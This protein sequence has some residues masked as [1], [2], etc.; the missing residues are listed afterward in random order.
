M[1]LRKTPNG[2]K[3]SLLKAP[4]QIGHIELDFTNEIWRPVEGLPFDV[5]DQG[6]VKR[7]NTGRLMMGRPS[8][9]TGYI[10]LCLKHAEQKFAKTIP[11]HQLV[12]KAFLPNP[13]NKPTVDHINRIRH[14]NRLCNLRWATY[15]EQ[16]KNR[17][18]TGK[19]NANR[20]VLQIDITTGSTIAEFE[21]ISAAANSIHDFSNCPKR[22]AFAYIQKV[23]SGTKDQAFGY[24]WKLVDIPDFDGEEWKTLFIDGFLFTI[25][26]YGRIQAKNGRRT[27]G[28]TDVH[29]YKSCMSW[30]GGTKGKGK[31]AKIHR[32]VA[33]A[34]IPQTDPLRIH[35]NH[36]NGIKDD[37]RVANLEWVTQKENSIH[38]YY[39][40]G[41]R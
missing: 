9:V 3:M 1:V 28:S 41:K 24:K 7:R 35:V 38:A 15:T 22:T 40:L 19:S 25:S 20:P 32:L 36:I 14:D 31:T 12:A 8:P 10:I 4:T 13:L 11:I 16:V 6:R 34:F 18:T 5:S 29:G 37:N 26:N 33:Q 17:N 39:V 27:Y 23:C 30:S 2:K 21:S